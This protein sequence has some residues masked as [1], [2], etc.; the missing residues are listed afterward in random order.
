MY[1]WQE[2]LFHVFLNVKK[3]VTFPTLQLLLFS[4]QSAALG[5]DK[6]GA[7]GPAGATGNG[8]VVPEAEAEARTTLALSTSASKMGHFSGGSCWLYTHTV[9]SG[10]MK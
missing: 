1:F 3:D 6:G 10:Q 2:C 5:A 8:D 9:H 7:G 4:T